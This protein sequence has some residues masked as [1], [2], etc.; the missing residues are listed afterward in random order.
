MSII[1][2]NRIQNTPKIKKLKKNTPTIRKSIPT[3]KYTATSANKNIYLNTKR[4]KKNHSVNN[5][6]NFSK[7]SK[8]FSI[9]FALFIIG[10]ISGISILADITE[11]LPSYE[12]LSSYDPPTISRLYSKNSTIIAEFANEKRIFT[13]YNEIPQ[14]I[15][16]AFLA[17]EDKY[18]FKHSGINFWSILRA[19]IQNTINSKENKRAVG[20]STI[21]QQVVKDFLLTNERTA[22][23]KIK[24][25]IL[26][27]RITKVYSKE[28][29]LELYLNQIFLGNNSYGIAVAAQNYFSKNLNELTI[30]DAA[31]LAALPKAPSSINPF[32]NYA[33]AKERRDWV[34]KRMEED[35]AITNTEA[36]Q[37]IKSQIELKKRHIKLQ[38]GENF[39]A[40]TIKQ[41]LIATYGEETLYKKGL[42]I[43]INMDENLQKLTD[44][45][46]KKGLVSYDRKYGYRGPIAKINVNDSKINDTLWINEL[47]KITKPSDASDYDIA[48]VLELNKN[49]VK[50]GF[51]NGHY[52]IINFEDMKWAK[53]HLPGQKI[54]SPIKKP[55][56]ALNLG[57]VILVSYINNN[58]YRLE[59][60]PD[61][62]GGMIVL[63]P[64]TGKVLAMVGGYNFN[65]TFFN[66]AI[67]AKRQP[68][69][70]FK[71]FTYLAALEDGF[72]E[73]SL[74]LD[75]PI[76]LYQ[77]PNMPLWTPK[78][79]TNNFTNDPVTLKKAFSNSMN[80]PSIRL[81]ISVGLD[82]VFNLST[83]MGVYSTQPKYKNYAAALG[84]FET[85]L[86]DITNAYNIIASSGFKTTPK[87]I[88][89]IYDRRG[90][91]IYS[92]DTI[93]CERC[94]KWLNINEINIDA[95]ANEK[96]LLPSI[97]YLRERIVP[98]K[99]NKQIISL[100]ES[101]VQEGSANKAKVLNK[102][103]GGKTGTTNNS[104]DA[105]FIGFSADLTVGI[106]VGFDTPKTLGKEAFG[107]NIALPIF[108]DF[109]QEALK[110][111]SNRPLD[112]DNTSNNVRIINVN[113][114]D[115]NEDNNHAND[116]HDD[117][118]NTIINNSI[119]YDNNLKTNTE[120][121]NYEILEDSTSN[122]INSNNANNTN[123]NTKNILNDVIE[124]SKIKDEII[125]SDKDDDQNHIFNYVTN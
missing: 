48:I 45:S 26:A 51:I 67:Q 116:N 66:R 32:S 95:N 34:I 13:P 117:S 10:L 61:V 90:N 74:I 78:N 79:V 81:L 15:I 29:I 119:N 107:S 12:Q 84:S 42:T 109:M 8:L 82:K 121:D 31:L 77:G 83:K 114:E 89:S 16:N 1:T 68:G 100:L 112:N 14:N 41:D 22:V 72:T 9:L 46:F 113:G 11:D 86:I 92:D 76:S 53:K 125:K 101:V 50:I 27:Y 75:A 6:F 85:T 91:L 80:L 43:N 25:A 58:L 71:T 59:Q 69:S 88:D 20:G 60:V 94:D 18:F 111:Y 23:R 104:F 3:N 63:Q 62:N 5:L 52:G 4:K 28:K 122:T 102:N 99:Y 93:I 103:I 19:M 110:N 7:I 97:N 54:A 36:K 35:G 40:E 123:T 56:D 70:A 2:P 38:S 55:A 118:N 65:T 37:Y 44:E 105:W 96:N 33:R 108:V 39:Y 24:E 98:E 57:D 115:F 120:D 49:T 124:N 73:D 47:K 106:Y 21:T 87:L 64:N 30:P 17:A